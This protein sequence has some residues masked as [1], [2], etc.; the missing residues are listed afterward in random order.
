MQPNGDTKDRHLL[1]KL[2]EG[3]QEAF[4]ALFFA[5]E[6]VLYTYALKLTHHTEDA[7]EIV[8]EVFIKVWEKRYETDSKRNF[9]GYLYTIAKHLVYNK[10]KRRVYDFAYKEYLTKQRTPVA[11]DTE[12]HI[13]FNELNELIHTA[14]QKLPPTRRKVFTLSRRDGLS[15]QEIANQLDTSTSNVKNHINKA[16][17][18]LKE[19]IQIH[20]MIPLIFLSYIPLFF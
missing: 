6:P 14:S 15:N 1:I 11:L 16:L 12:N 7:K 19:Q 17:R 10:A 5:Y 13:Q 3:N 9:G 20:E 4:N 18:F 8:Q 2:R